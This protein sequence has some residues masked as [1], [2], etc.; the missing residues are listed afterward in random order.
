MIAL[1]RDAIPLAAAMRRAVVIPVAVAILVAVAAALAGRREVAG[2][3]C[4]RRG[5]QRRASVR[6]AGGAVYPAA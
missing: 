1:S 3:H 5:G 2:E 4:P 6:G